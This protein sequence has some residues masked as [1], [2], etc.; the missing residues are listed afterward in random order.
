MTGDD[1]I[2]LIDQNGIGEAEALDGHRN[3]MKLL[4]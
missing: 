4:F 2:M 3:L 1:D